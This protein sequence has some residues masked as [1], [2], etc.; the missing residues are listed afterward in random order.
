MPA[1]IGSQ[2]PP[3]ASFCGGTS[4][5]EGESI[6]SWLE[7][8]LLVA[9]TYKWNP[10]FEMPNLVMRLEEAFYQ[11]CPPET[12]TNFDALVRELQ[13]RLT[14]V[15][16]QGVQTSLFHDRQQQNSESVDKFAQDL[17]KLYNKAYP[18]SMRGGE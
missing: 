17:R 15:R 9:S 10:Q 7:R 16:I 14:R 8:F 4:E 13:T 3:L 11:S 6:E 1:F 2:L 12:R 5:G 18:P